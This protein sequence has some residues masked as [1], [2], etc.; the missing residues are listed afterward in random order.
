[1]K[2]IVGEMWPGVSVSPFISRGATD[3]R[4]LRAAGI[5]SYGMDPMPVTESEGRRAHG[6]DERIP[7]PSLRTGLEFMHRLVLALAAK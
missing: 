4:Y 1:V 5:A 3:S 2:K 6:V 7:A